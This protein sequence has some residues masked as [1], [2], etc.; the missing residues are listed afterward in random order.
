MR[1]TIASTLALALLSTSACRRLHRH[2]SARHA[3]TAVHWFTWPAQGLA[4]RV[5]ASR[6]FRGAVRVEDGHAAPAPWPA[7]AIVSVARVDNG[8][9][10]AC[11]DGSLYRSTTF[12][13][14]LTS[15]GGLTSRVAPLEAD[16]AVASV[17]P[18]S[19]GA[20][21][22]IDAQRD[23]WAVD[24]S[25]NARKLPLTRVRHGVFASPT[26]VFAV[27]EPGALVHST[28]GGA[29]FTPV[30]LSQGAALSVLVDDRGVAVRTTEGALRWNNGALAPATDVAAPS[31]ANALDRDQDAVVA[32]AAEGIPDVPWRPGAVAS[33]PDGTVSMVRNDAAVTVDPA[34]G[35]ERSRVLLPGEDCVLARAR[36]GLRAVCRQGGWALTVSALADGA[37]EWTL[38]RDERRAEPMGPAFF[39]RTSRAWIVGAP[40][41]QRTEPDPHRVCFYTDAGEPVELR[42]PFTAV[43]VSMHDGAALLID[44]DT[45]R[46]ASTRA[47]I[48]T[49]TS[50][51]ELFLPGNV[52]SA[53]SATLDGDALMMW[54]VDPDGDHLLAL[55]RGERRGDSFEWHRVDAPS[56]TRRGVIAQGGRAI[57]AGSDAS[58][59]A[60]ST[61][62]GPF[63]ALPSP[64]DGAG[65][66][67]ELSMA[68][69]WFCA[70]PWC[71]LGGNLLMSTAGS[72]DVGVVARHDAAP[73]IEVTRR[74]RRVFECHPD[75]VAT[76]G[77]D[78]DR[79]N[80]VSG[81]AIRS[82]VLGSTVNLTWYGAT[83]NGSASV[84]WAG[85]M[86]DL[87]RAIGATMAT[88]PGAMLER[89]S[90][91]ACERAF[92]WSRGVAALPLP[93]TMPGTAALHAT[94]DGWIARADDLR[95]GAPRV[96]L[97]AIDARGIVTAER[98][99][100]LASQ[101]ARADAGTFGGAAGLWVRE[102]AT[103]LRFHPIG[104]GA[105][106]TV[107]ESASGCDT[108]ASSPEGMVFRVTEVS[109]VRG[110]DW[111]VDPSE[112]QLE[113]RLRVSSGR[114]CVVSIAGG[115]PRDE[116]E[117][118]E[119]RRE[120][121]PVRTMIL[122]TTGA[123]G[124]R[125]R[126]W[127]GHEV[128][129]QRCVLRPR[130]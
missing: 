34:T 98:T 96:T 94:A 75:G 41:R 71:R 20:L 55:I 82:Q 122:E 102:G 57:V 74:P 129:A 48:V 36:D 88:A 22:V 99:F 58:L 63:T 42:V 101:D 78:M 9:L 12:T 11:E 49:A 56:G 23:A 69:Q 51:K 26:E 109:A 95:E 110:E 90:Q 76:P 93:R 37:H 116:V 62:G 27:V 45:R 80:A 67:F 24:A 33:N 61:R 47:A 121:T 106:T 21:F 50:T 18:R 44:G 5:D 52:M 64:V 54:D 15:I 115:E 19:E 59:L 123:D 28:D 72:R 43:L 13:G 107:E 31:V 77:V 128:H 35:V 85:A 81:Y 53:Q 111:L 2:H 125:A 16:G 86:G 8:W 83:L 120:H 25:G 17:R 1:P 14:R 65:A 10:F 100:T 105:T 84:T 108:S 130:R 79:G 92:A 103:A 68:G 32:R 3:S 119:A 29:S 89:C 46:A 118:R 38:L 127:A 113:E 112:W 6:F 114:A 4:A 97:V 87:F 91:G 40:C 7:A 66:A 39:D 30:A 70:G 73:A 104:G 126:A 117:E 124:A 60:M